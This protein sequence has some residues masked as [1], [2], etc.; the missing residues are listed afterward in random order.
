MYYEGLG[1]K[2]DYVK[3]HILWKLASVNSDVSSLKSS[4]ENLS[5]DRIVVNSKMRRS[6]RSMI[7]GN[8]AS[9]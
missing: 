3:A 8:L 1:V 2:Q 9:R 4:P 5:K 6:N 7:A